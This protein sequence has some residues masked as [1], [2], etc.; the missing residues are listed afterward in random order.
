MEKIP[1]PKSA[2]R[3]YDTTTKDPEASEGQHTL[4]WIWL[5]VQPQGAESGGDDVEN[6]QS[7][8]ESKS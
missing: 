5:A 6:G 4:S 7:I 3:A 2:R 8:N 1:K